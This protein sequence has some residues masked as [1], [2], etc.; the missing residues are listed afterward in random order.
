MSADVTLTVNG[1]IYGGWLEATVTR[2]LNAIAGKFELATTDRWSQ[3]SRPWVIQPGDTCELK[4]ANQVLITGYVDSVETGIDA[5]QRTI[6]I[7]GR[8]KTGDFVDCSAFHTPGEYRNKTLK[9][10]AEILAGPFGIS[11]KIEG[12]LGAPFPKFVIDPGETAF[13]ALERAARL[14][15]LLLFNNGQGS[16]VI[17]KT[18]ASKATTGLQQGEN[19]LEARSSFTMNERFSEYVVLGQLTMP[20]TELLPEQKVHIQGKATDKGISRYR[21]LVIRAEGPCTNAQ[22]KVRAQWEATVR[23]A[24]AAKFEVTTVGWKKADG[25]LWTINELVE[26]KSEWLGV[27]MTLLCSEIRYQYGDRGEIT[28]LTLERPDAYE[29]VDGLEK[30]KGKKS[31]D[32]WAELA[33]GVKK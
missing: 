4:I 10:I 18:A 2:S 28:S 15:G 26:L 27:D 14:R 8:D 30:K 9:Q 17:G 13:Q 19:I 23:A 16:V 33:K 20:D 5:S 12:S 7:S 21:P 22:A 32:P 25:S 31:V 1:K 6:A 3:Q 11:V 29:P 24:R